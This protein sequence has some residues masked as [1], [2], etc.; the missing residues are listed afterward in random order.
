MSIIRANCRDRLIGKDVDFIQSVL[1]S[2]DGDRSVIVDLLT[3]PDSI[4]DEA[5]LVDAIQ[6]RAEWLTIS[7]RLYFYLLVRHCFQVRSIEDRDVADYVADL[8][9][10]FASAKRVVSPLPDADHVYDRVCDML[11][12]LQDQ[13]AEGRFRIRAHIANYALFL[14]GIFPDRIARRKERRGAPGL[15]YYEQLGQANFHEASTLH[16]AGE[17]D[18]HKIFARLAHW[19]R[20]ARVGLNDLAD[21]FLSVGTSDADILPAQ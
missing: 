20:E 16:L 3:D 7:S 8:L 2:N 12:A 4:L 5:R 11:L 18:L 17:Y 19:F 10:N 15:D 1:G 13:D 14:T 21:R 6:D 9:A